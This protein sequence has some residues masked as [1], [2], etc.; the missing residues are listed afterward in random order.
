MDYTKYDVPMTIK[1]AAYH[2]S[3]ILFVLRNFVTEIWN[4][5]THERN[6]R[7]FA[8][9]HI[10]RVNIAHFIYSRLKQDQEQV[11]SQ[12]YFQVPR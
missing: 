7:A 3:D 1:E 10:G 2:V 11:F 6:R 12:E 8:Q 5:R 4:G 9:N